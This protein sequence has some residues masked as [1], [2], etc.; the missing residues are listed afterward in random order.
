[1][2]EGKSKSV[3]ELFQEVDV[4]NNLP[5]NE[6]L[7]SGICLDSRDVKAGCL[8]LAAQGTRVDGHTYITDAVSSGA[9]LVVGSEPSQNYSDLP[10]PYLQVIN[11][12][13]TLAHLTAAWYG[14]PARKLIVI[15]VTGTDGKTTTVNLIHQILL[16]AGMKAG[17][18]STVNAVIGEQ[19]L[20][21]GFHVTTPEA[22][23]VQ[24]YLAQMLEA[25]ITHVVLEATSHGL[26]QK[27]VA[28]CEFD[29]AVVTNITH[30]HLD[31]HGDY[32]EYLDAKA[33]L[34]RL[35]VISKEKNTPYKK[36]AIINK[37]DISYPALSEIV[38]K[39][40]V[41]MIDFGINETAD[42]QAHKIQQRSTGL[43]FTVETTGH[44][45]DFQTSLM[46]D[47]NVSNCLG[48]LALCIEGLGIDWRVVV[49]GI[50]NLTGI[51]GRMEYLDLGQK[52]S[53]IVDFAHTPNALSR[54]LTSARELTLKRV[55]TVFGSAGLR[56][57]EKRKLMAE[58][59]AEL[60]DLTILTAEDPRTESL[61]GILQEMAEGMISKGGIEGESFRRVP[62]RGGAIRFALELASPED[63][64]IVCGKGH[65]QSMCFEET[66]YPWDDRTALLSA[67]ADY[68]GQEGPNMPYLPTQLK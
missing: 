54:T 9:A 21:T 61:D 44:K 38:G 42:Y 1:M 29:M 13:E 47:Y 62:D 16:A 19:I 30:E 51:P 20:E 66:E 57:K 18:I 35:L 11:S 58:V 5:E 26:A 59:S 37:D 49:K 34:F 4:I 12:R 24:R 45:V 3:F 15:G 52:F 2:I 14:F 7:I 28:A 27:R 6:I 48:A 39:T 60:A 22:V 41:K 8:F 67:L 50:K 65:E 68:L 43:T 40:G 17:L 33:E 25:G 32:Q 36:V 53:V 55:I 63:V 31:Y 56:D 10:V 23:D 46:G 64:V